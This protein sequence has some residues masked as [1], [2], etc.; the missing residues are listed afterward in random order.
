MIGNQVSSVLS[1]ADIL[2][3]R[4]RPDRDCTLLCCVMSYL[5]VFVSVTP[6]AWHSHQLSMDVCMQAHLLLLNESN[7]KC[8]HTSKSKYVNCT[9]VD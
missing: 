2:G 7:A 1:I 9:P 4:L 3:S 6:P 5:C 8:K